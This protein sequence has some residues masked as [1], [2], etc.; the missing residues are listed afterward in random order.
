MGCGYTDGGTLAGFLDLPICW[1]SLR[2]GLS[3][4]ESAMGDIQI[5][6]REESEVDAILDEVKAHRENNDFEEHSCNMEDHQHP[7][8]PML[9]VSYG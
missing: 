5:K 8:L 1:D 9:K 4:V 2:N 6:K 7:P 3:R